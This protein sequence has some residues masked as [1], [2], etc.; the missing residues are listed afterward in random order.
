MNGHVLSASL[1]GI[2]INLID[3]EVSFM[4]GLPG[5]DMV[6]MLSSEVKEARERVTSVLHHIGFPLPSMRQKIRAAQ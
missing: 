4:Y 5:V 3:V 2:N 6:G 1:F